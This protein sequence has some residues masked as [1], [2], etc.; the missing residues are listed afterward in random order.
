MVPKEFLGAFK[1]GHRR[2]SQEFIDEEF[3]WTLLK[4]VYEGCEEARKALTWLT[5]FNNE[6]HKKVIKKN[7]Q[8]AIHNSQFLYR[9][10]TQR[11]DARGRDLYTKVMLIRNGEFFE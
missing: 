5:K 4:K 2:P 3:S 7:D 9:D 11:E 1:R 10:C 8:N 6:Y